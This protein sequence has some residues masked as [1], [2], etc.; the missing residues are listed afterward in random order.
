MLPDIDYSKY[1]G[2]PFEHGMRDIIKHINELKEITL[3][4]EHLRENNPA[5][6]EAYERYQIIKKLSK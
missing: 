2:Q 6:Q 5:L 4:D 3:F 1:E